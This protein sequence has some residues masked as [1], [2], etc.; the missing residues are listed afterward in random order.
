MTIL[1][2][3][4]SPEQRLLNSVVQAH[5]VTEM[6]EEMAPDLLR[7][8]A[9]AAETAGLLMLRLRAKMPYQL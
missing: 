1:D 9:S 5:A 3:M 6:L 8:N 7:I 2:D 4:T